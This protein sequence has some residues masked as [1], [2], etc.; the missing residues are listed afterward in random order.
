MLILYLPVQTNNYEI[1]LGEENYSIESVWGFHENSSLAEI[2][3]TTGNISADSL[4][5]S[6]PSLSAYH[7][8]LSSNNITGKTST[9]S[10]EIKLTQLNKNQFT[11]S[12]DVTW[13]LFDIK[14][15]LLQE[16]FGKL[17]D[18]RPMNT[19]FYIINSEN[20]SWKIIK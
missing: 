10:Y 3:G 19:G 11:L 1:K 8:V 5:F 15:R 20:K 16:N 9:H 13:K 2:T 12:Q 6:V 18:L 4:Y 7:V 14:G 17:I